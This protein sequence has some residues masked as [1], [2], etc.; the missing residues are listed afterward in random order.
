MR[1]LALIILFSI[2]AIQDAHAEFF[3][4]AVSS[5]LGESGR[6]GM[7]GAEGAFLNPALV[8]LHQGYEL[9]GYFR[10]GYID[11][12]EHRQAWGIGAIDQGRDVWF[13]GS[14]HY[15]RLRD[16][17]RAP[18]A[19]DGELW[20]VA[21]GQPVSDSLSLGVTAYRLQYDVSGDRSYDQWNYSLGS[22]VL[23]NDSLTFGYVLNNLAKP[24]SRVPRGLREDLNQ[25]LAASLAFGQM[26]RLRADIGRQERFNPDHKLKWMFGFESMTDKFVVMRLGFIRDEL[27]DTKI[28]TGGVGLNGPRLKL[29]YSAQKNQE[30]TSGVLHSVDLRLPF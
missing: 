11:S 4:G 17:G 25:A 23:V 16:T 15:L 10:D 30:R 5:A 29:E 26:V 9:A 8:A 12:Q 18:T 1:S 24:G 2:S 21:I 3:K 19:A 13:P 14:I 22:L 6:A 20:H 27:A 7:M 28:Y